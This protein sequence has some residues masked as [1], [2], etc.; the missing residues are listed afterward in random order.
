MGRSDS[1]RNNCR[2]HPKHKNST[3]V[4]PYCLK[5]RLV[6]LS[7]PP[8]SFFN[9]ACSTSASSTLFY[10]SESDLSSLD[11]SPMHEKIQNAKIMLLKDDKQLRDALPIK[12]GGVGEP[13]LK[14]RSLIHV[15]ERKNELLRVERGNNEEDKE[16]KKEKKA[17]FWLKFLGGGLRREEKGEKSWSLRHSRTLKENTSAKWV[18]FF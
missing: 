10:S 14:S 7:S 15:V 8:F 17:S 1:D 4:C 16:E 6:H 11:E 3:G 9:L 18:R 5:E 2:K 12:R 13:L